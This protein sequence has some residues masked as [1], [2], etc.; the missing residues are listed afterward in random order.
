MSSRRQFLGTLSAGALGALWINAAATRTVQAAVARA[1]G[2]SPEDLA[3]DE[4]F[5]FQVQQ[6]YTVDRSMINLNNGGVSPTVRVAQEA[7]RRHYE[8]ANKAPS[9]TMWQQQDPQVETVRTGLADAFGCD[10]EEMAITRNA[11]ESLEILIYGIDLKA[12]DEVVAAA[13]DY[14]RMLNTYR[15]RE[16]RD[17]IKLNLIDLPSPVT[18]AE[19]VVAA[20]EAALTPR[21][22][23]ILCSHVIFATGQIMPVRALCD[24]G[25]RRGIPVIVDGAHAF[26]H[27]DFRRDDL[28][29]D[30]YGTSL[31]KWLTAPHGT[32]FLYVR[33]ARIGDIWPLMAAPEPRGTDIRKFEEIGTHPAANRL[34]V[35][36]ALGVYGALGA[37]RKLARL[38]HLRDRWIARVAGDR[39]V[40]FATKL[41]DAHTGG[42]TTVEIEGIEPS[43]LTGYLWQQ[44]RIIV[45]PI[46]YGGVRGIR[47]SPNVYTTVAE[48][49]LFADVL[50]AVLANG[51]PSGQ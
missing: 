50:E 37:A 42:F 17:G 40:R 48:V 4:D 18:D 8:H 25:R 29:C 39:R 27:L 32:G 26:A 24:L 35:A 43:P 44:H 33:R 46:D 19:A 41:D 13:L 31:H 14:P 20:Y 34:A 30:L 49:D 51:L 21:T 11:S 22:R 16:L 6:A 7:M 9:R 23:V 3:R 10:R 47:V 2:R 15:Q 45:T 5:W 36:E 28:D 1:G 38:R 12:G